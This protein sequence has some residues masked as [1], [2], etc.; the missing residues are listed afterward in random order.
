MHPF[1]G[2]FIKLRKATISFIMS[3][4]QA[5]WNNSA[6]T[7]RILVKLDSLLFWKSVAKIQI[8]L[9]SGK[10]NEYIT[11]RRFDIY[12]NIWLNSS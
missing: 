4:R 12:D 10:N 9:K 1:L 7:G 8:L 2:T 6:P 3:I 11:W 5:A